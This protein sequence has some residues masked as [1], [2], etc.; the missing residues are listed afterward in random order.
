[1][2]AGST[3]RRSS[4]GTAPGIRPSPHALSITPSRGSTTTTLRPASR[5]SIAEASPTGPPPT[6]MTSTSDE[7]TQRPIL[8]GDAEAQQQHGVQ[9]GERDRGDPRRVNQGHRYALDRDD[10]VVRVRQQPIEAA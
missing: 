3:P 1:M 4:K 5:A 2:P 8:G 9:D 7:L 6:T 10:H